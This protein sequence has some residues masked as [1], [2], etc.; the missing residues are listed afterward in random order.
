VGRFDEDIACIG[1]RQQ[2]TRLQAGDK[3][4]RD[5]HVGAS[6]EMERDAFL[7]QR[8]LE[9]LHG[10]TDFRTGIMIH[11]RQDV[12]RAG[13]CGDTIGDQGLRHR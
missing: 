3:V 11:T 4:R 6:H 8:V 13:H 10:S 1:K 12:G 5:V 9:L 2:V 7:I